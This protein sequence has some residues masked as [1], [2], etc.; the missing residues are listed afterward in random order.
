MALPYREVTELYDKLK[1]AG[2]VTQSLPDWSAEMGRVTGTDLYNEGLHDNF[3]RRSSVGLDRLL[4]ATGLPEV[5]ADFGGAVGSWF[6]K[7]AVGRE[8]GR[9]IPRGVLDFAPLAL[10]GPVGIGV[11]AALSGLHTYADTGSI[12]HGIASAATAGLLPGV[13][14]R[15]GQAVL[16]KLGARYLSEPTM[17]GFEDASALNKYLPVVNNARYLPESVPVT[18]RLLAHGAEQVAAGGLMGAGQIAGEALDPNQQ[19]QNPF[20]PDFLL[21]TGLQTLPFS[22]LHAGREILNS[23]IRPAYDPA[24]LDANIKATRD[25][26]ERRAREE[27]LANSAPVTQAPDWIQ[28]TDEE[29]LKSISQASDLIAQMTGQVKEES[30]APAPDLD[31]II[32]KNRVIREA[33]ASQWDKTRGVGTLDG[34]ELAPHAD[35]IHV[36][37][38]GTDYVRSRSGKSAT[39]TV[40]DTPENV[41]AGLMPGQRINYSVVKEQKGPPVV[42]EGS[43][44]T[45][46]LPSTHFQVLP[47]YRAIALK[48][49]QETWQ[50]ENPTLP[51]TEAPT[52]VSRVHELSAMVARLQDLLN[53]AILS[54]DPATLH[55][56]KQV[57]NQALEAGGFNPWD[58]A[59]FA[60]YQD[61]L[62]QKAEGKK[63]TQAEALR[64]AQELLMSK[65]KDKEDIEQA[66]VAKMEEVKTRVTQLKADPEQKLSDMPPTDL[67]GHL[68]ESLASFKEG[69]FP[70]LFWSIVDKWDKGNARVKPQAG[71][72]ERLDAMLEEAGRKNVKTKEKGTETVPAPEVANIPLDAL[73][74]RSQELVPEMQ[75][76]RNRLSNI[77]SALVEGDW[78]KLT[79]EQQVAAHAWVDALDRGVPVTEAV[80]KLLPINEWQ[81]KMADIM[82]QRGVKAPRP[83]TEKRNRAGVVGGPVLR[84][85]GNP[86]LSMFQGKVARDAAGN[87]TL[88]G[89]RNVPTGPM[90]EVE[91]QSRT[92]ISPALLPLFKSHYPEAFG[93]QKVARDGQVR[94]EGTVDVTKL[95]KGLE[96]R[97]LTGVIKAGEEG[98]QRPELVRVE[99]ELDGINP[100]W[101]GMTPSDVSEGYPEAERTRIEDLFARQQ[102]LARNQDRGLSYSSHY[103][104]S[105]SPRSG[106]EIAVVAKGGPGETLPSDAHHDVP[107]LLGTA[108]VEEKTLGELR[109]TM[110]ADHPKLA[111]FAGKP[112]DAVIGVQTEAQ[113]DWEG[114]QRDMLERA[115]RHGADPDF[116]GT[117]EQ[118]DELERY[119]ISRHPS[120]PLLPYW[121]RLVADAVI[122]HGLER[123]WEGVVVTDGKTALMT[124]GHDTSFED[125][126]AE[127]SATKQAAEARA[128]ALTTENP[129]RA[130]HVEERAGVSPD[131]ITYPWAVI[132]TGEPAVTISQSPGMFQHYGDPDFRI[133]P[134]QMPGSLQQE[135][136]KATGERNTILG[137]GENVLAVGVHKGAEGYQNVNE[138][139]EFQALRDSWNR[140]EITDEQYRQQV[141]ELKQRLGPKGSPSL[142]EPHPI[143]GTIGPKVYATGN[144]YSF[145]KI[146][147]GLAENPN[148]SVNEASRGVKAPRPFVPDSASDE[149]AILRMGLGKDGVALAQNLTRDSDLGSLAQDLLVRFPD[150]LKRIISSLSEGEGPSS[151]IRLQ[152][153][154]VRLD[155]NSSL[156]M[157]SKSD[158]NFEIMHE[159]IHGL[160]RHAI[161]DGKN[162]KAIADLTTLRE[163]LVKALPKDMKEGYD[164]A[165]ASNW[166][167]RYQ[168]DD[169]SAKVDDLHLDWKK[170]LVLYGL[171]DNE[172]LLAQGFSSREMKDFM[173]TVRGQTTTGWKA[174]TNWVKKTLGMEAAWKGTAFDEFMDHSNRIMTSGDV[175]A[176]ANNFFDDWFKQ[177]GE[178]PTDARMKSRRTMGVLAGMRWGTEPERILASLNEQQAVP[179]SVVAL[180]TKDLNVMIQEKGEDFADA[181][182]KLAELGFSASKSDVD[183]LVDEMLMDGVSQNHEIALQTLPEAVTKYVYAKLNDQRDVLDAVR[184][185]V[186]KSNENLLDISHPQEVRKPVS[187]TMKKIDSV[188]SQDRL[189]DE[190]IAQMQSALG[191]APDVFSQRAMAPR[192]TQQATDM[193]AEDSLASLTTFQ[194][195]FS[196]MGRV[197]K[198]NPMTAELI[199]KGFNLIPSARLMQGD[200]GR[201]LSYDLN[202]FGAGPTEKGAAETQRVYGN[203]KLH[204]IADSWSSLNQFVAQKEK[205]GVTLL[206][207]NHPK[208]EPLLRG[209]TQDE[210][211]DVIDSVTKS[212]AFNQGMQK[213]VEQKLAEIGITEAAKV[214]VADTKGKAQDG[215]A[216]SRQV[217]DA[218]TNPNPT[219]PEVQAKLAAVQSHMTPEGFLRLIQVMKVNK[220]MFDTVVTDHAENPARLSAQRQ[221]NFLVRFNV[222]GEKQLG[223]ADSKTQAEALVKAR[224]GSNMTI[225]PNGK[226]IDQDVFD[227]GND[228]AAVLKRFAELDQNRF[229]L[230][231]DSMT[232]EQQAAYKG[233]LDPVV[234]LAREAAAAGVARVPAPSRLLSQGAEYLP[235]L[236]NQ[237]TGSTKQSNY[238]TRRLFRTQAELHLGTPEMLANSELRSQMQSW[239]DGFLRQDPQMIQKVNRMASTWFMGFSPA[240]ALMNGLQTLS[241]LTPELT[242]MNGG[243]VIDSFRR[244]G[245]AIAEVTSGNGWKTPERSRFIE[246]ATKAGEVDFSQYDPN[247]ITQEQTASKLVQILDG[248]EVRSVAQRLKGPAG[249]FSTAAFAPFRAVEKFNH[250]V[251][252]ISAFDLARDQ[253]MTYE[254]AKQTAFETNRAVNY[255]GGRAQRPILPFSGRDPFSRGVAMLATNMQNYNLGVVGQLGQYLK[256]SLPSHV[257]LKPGDKYAARKAAI[258]M[259]G[260]QFAAAGVLGMPFVAGGLALLNQLFPGLELGKNLRQGV[261]A[262]LDDDKD[263]NG[264]VW[265][266]IA[267]TGLPSMLGWDMQSRLSMGNLVP[268]ISE[269]NGF[270]PEAMLGPSYSL[271]KQFVSGTARLSTGDARGAESFLPPGV[272]K[273]AQLLQNEGVVKNYKDE[274]LFSP[275]PGE[276]VG[277][278]LGFNPKRASDTNAA[279]RML[280]QSNRLTKT[281]EGQW[282]QGQ[283][284]D[285]M[286]GNFG[287]VRQ[288]LMERLRQDSSY[289]VRESAQAIAG[290]AEDLTFPRDLRQQGSVAT[291]PERQAVLAAFS[292]DPTTTSEVDR[293][294][295]RQGILQRL[296]LPLPA[297]PMALRLAT[298]T[299]QL[300]AASPGATRAM[301]RSQA[302][303]ML[304]APRVQPSLSESQ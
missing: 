127:Y 271:M 204:A 63:V 123:G 224:G 173:Q 234:Q 283:A 9:S 64:G 106:T 1:A 292:V 116:V 195:M 16:G 159:L 267:L 179:T 171:L 101:R 280:A 221:Q 100:Q 151:A 76:L 263:H 220:E 199:N 284:T 22:A 67:E 240:T 188:L 54:G 254:Q 51:A 178:T 149:T 74:E 301:L 300:R 24:K 232:P 163:R 202:D 29:S 201:I 109:T 177:R 238:W 141:Q 80:K 97:P 281:R 227:L 184:G 248:N 99:H 46:Q 191:T 53:K 222:N 272:K 299:D 139:P 111:R 194:K 244:W 115:K 65:V 256:E 176:R 247:E 18:S 34:I 138:S 86:V 112:D 52:D 23:Q 93:K 266:D 130:Y 91:F 264:S 231:K 75:Q 156:L 190:A 134:Q 180:A 210:K 124:E 6:G 71:G 60:D 200:A 45:V 246:D 279:D 31:A 297:S 58:D 41:D 170:A 259:L 206:A 265:S 21:S 150:A 152:D 102:D 229:D 126:V 140:K 72:V 189:H 175:V 213:Q 118:R 66:R 164:R 15:V 278:A 125:N 169:P 136:A 249:A 39:F 193:L 137:G 145:D 304:G 153:N 303:T 43:S 40:A 223:Q 95:M 87:V 207:P 5:G 48:A 57:F 36:P 172:E 30:A 14:E 25:G 167:T 174:F 77:A 50:K 237:L 132:R 28:P 187:A 105:S 108:T 11:A 113:S 110:G 82:A 277:I 89:G 288:A 131:D 282:R 19:I 70:D 209:L 42:G 286:K 235:W 12:A 212:V 27:E 55:E 128:K 205:R 211:K 92:A 215:I 37:V 269:L 243:R 103:S 62:N 245:S 208:V 20:T 260:T 49:R 257:E 252:L 120:H 33:Q 302:R 88:L 122:Q 291:S 146:R 203:K 289:D 56:S 162:E 217:W 253:R 90:S 158:Q 218:V 2:A 285:V 295:F 160:T 35:T 69:R 107:G 81:E 236:R 121:E 4:E 73:V 290:A 79:E 233:R 294:R 117:Q 94:E 258:Q 98:T 148:A 85:W 261:S 273:L 216:L 198:S 239:V 255:G 287:S 276:A 147:S 47:D 143:T 251:T 230:M 32:A 192:Q 241:T 181:T 83:S 7:E 296:G 133:G 157:M 154:R 268:G 226:G 61:L 161:L 68:A 78:D 182:G 293:L 228:N 168:R 44:V 183:A 84:K 186:A 114:E 242:R 219:D 298:L 17:L 214:A 225:E 119:Y 196:L 274:P 13:T 197:A 96:E 3:I 129:G 38:T 185:A 8:A 59:R 104:I 26:L 155:F 262:F 144:Y 270:Q 166:M 142:T 275:T 250:Y 10:G 135:F 165:I